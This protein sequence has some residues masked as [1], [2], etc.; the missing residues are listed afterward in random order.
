[1]ST[2]IFLVWSFVAATVIA[3]LLFLL[4]RTRQPERRDFG[5]LEPISMV[6]T[7]LFFGAFIMSM[8]SRMLLSLEAPS[9]TRF[10]GASGFL[11][12]GLFNLINAHRD[13][14]R[15]SSQRA[16]S[17]FMIAFGLLRLALEIF[18]P[19]GAARTVP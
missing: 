16:I 11:V 8:T 14:S 12:L 9:W 6:A 2:P 15:Y 5:R 17:Y 10:V 18:D 4:D 13:G 19:G 1:M 7:I 3:A